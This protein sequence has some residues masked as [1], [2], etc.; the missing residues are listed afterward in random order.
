MNPE[1]I[2]KVSFLLAAF[3]SFLSS[4][5][6]YFQAGDVIRERHEVTS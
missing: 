6:M 4:V 3:A 2:L 5:T 1:R